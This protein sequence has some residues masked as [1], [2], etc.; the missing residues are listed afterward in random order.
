MSDVL[1]LIILWL[2]LF[3]LNFYL[4]ISISYFQRFFLIS[5]FQITLQLSVK[6]LFIPL[7]RKKIFILLMFN[8]NSL[9][10]MAE[11][12]NFLH[13]R[14]FFQFSFL[15]LFNLFCLSRATILFSN[16]IK[17]GRRGKWFSWEAMCLRWKVDEKFS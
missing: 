10:M 11:E 7:R 13:R 5:F 9:W 3:C 2:K 15:F 8:K 16:F 4:K 17:V 1:C 6:K 12:I 14:I